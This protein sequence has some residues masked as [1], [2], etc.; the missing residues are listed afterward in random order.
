MCNYWSNFVKTGNPNGV[1]NDGA[2]MP[3]WKPY[4]KE[5][6]CDMV[7]GKNGAEPDNAKEDALKEFL[8]EHGPDK[9]YNRKYY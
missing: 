4:S 7:F 9:R 8:I 1:D 2:P 6:P 5:I 3:E